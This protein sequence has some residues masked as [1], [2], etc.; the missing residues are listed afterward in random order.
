M[1]LRC[2][3]ATVSAVLLPLAG[4]ATAPAAARG[5]PA[6]HDVA[7]LELPPAVHDAALKRVLH[8]KHDE[9]SPETL[10]ADHLA[11][12]EA[13]DAAWTAL[14]PSTPRTDLAAGTIG[15]SLD[16]EMLAQI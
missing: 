16:T 3:L 13:L 9:V 5:E 8:D 6:L 1:R 15:R 4:C 12:G 2:V 11:I 7:V 10:A 14:A